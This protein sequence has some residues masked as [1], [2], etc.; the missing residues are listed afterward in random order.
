MR[1]T[2][3]P[4]G[5]RA[6]DTTY[7]LVNVPVRFHVLRRPGLVDETTMP[8][9]RLRRAVADWSADFIDFASFTFAG[10][11]Y[12]NGF[13]NTI[14]DSAVT[15]AQYDRIVTTSNPSGY[16]NEL[17]VT[18]CDLAVASGVGT[19]PFSFGV[20][21]SRHNHMFVDFRA[22]ACRGRDGSAIA[23]APAN[24]DTRW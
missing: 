19:Y 1:A 9:A 7:A 20:T 13:P 3:A 6:D 24:C 4:A 15:Q 5:V 2:P 14:V 18:V 8:A 12:I 23:G 11:D 16:M 10:V 17:H 21:H 22:V